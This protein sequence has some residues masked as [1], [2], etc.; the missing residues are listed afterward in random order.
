MSGSWLLLHIVAEFL[1]PKKVSLSFFCRVIR[2]FQQLGA[3]FLITRSIVDWGLFWG[4]QFME[5]PT[6]TPP[7][8]REKPARPSPCLQPEERKEEQPAELSGMV[9][10]SG[11]PIGHE[12]Y[13]NN[14][15]AILE[16]PYRTPGPSLLWLLYPS[17]W[18]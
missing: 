10:M 16:S 4:S 14:S 13:K 11:K 17:P 2:G 1:G 9:K 5:T 7:A 12:S 18:Q 8:N 3:L 15:G 6:N